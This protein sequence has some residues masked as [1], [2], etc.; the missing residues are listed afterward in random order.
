M[1]Y[2][3]YTTHSWWI[4]ISLTIFFMSAGGGAGAGTDR[5]HIQTIEKVVE[6]RLGSELR[7]PARLDDF[8]GNTRMNLGTL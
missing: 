3:V 7:E 4:W 1:V 5:P 2:Q 8:K 6:A